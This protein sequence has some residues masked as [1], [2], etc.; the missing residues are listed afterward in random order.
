[1]ISTLK[2]SFGGLNIFVTVFSSVRPVSIA[3]LI[4]ISLA[5]N[6]YANTVGLHYN[7]LGGS[8]K[9]SMLYLKYVIPNTI[10]HDSTSHGTGH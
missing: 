10:Q 5:N 7:I 9:F 4:L 1:M 8:V 3:W 6:E 2:Q